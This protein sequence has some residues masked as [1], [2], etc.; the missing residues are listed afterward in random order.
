MAAP[1]F[2][3]VCST[4]IT[5]N[6]TAI[7]GGPTQSKT[8]RANQNGLK[9][10]VKTKKQKTHFTCTAIEQSYSVASQMNFLLLCST[11]IYAKY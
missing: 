1:Y 6:C 7:L 8:N 2:L 11:N 5:E 4:E 9:D 10:F 3:R